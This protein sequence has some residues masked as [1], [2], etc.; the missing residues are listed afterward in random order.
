MERR[1]TVQV[2][3]RKFSAALGS[4]EIRKGPRP[5]PPLV[6]FECF[7]PTFRP[8]HNLL[9]VTTRKLTCDVQ[10]FH[11]YSIGRCADLCCTR[12][13]R[14]LCRSQRRG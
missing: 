12:V 11:T 8:T 3:K 6:S 5:I 9:L 1:R 14:C 13:F 4:R 2:Q 7:T 10:F